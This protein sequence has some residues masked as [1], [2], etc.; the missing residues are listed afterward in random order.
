MSNM[1]KVTFQK[2]GVSAE[3]TGEHDSILELAEANNLDLDYGCR[4]GNCT[5]CMQVLVSGEVDYPNDHGGE[6]D[7][8]SILTCCSVPKGDVVID[9]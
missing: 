4:E 2:S 1:A 7:E 6:P 9:A 3:W 8:G 5:A